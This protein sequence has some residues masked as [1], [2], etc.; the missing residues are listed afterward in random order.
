MHT[1]NE[2]E[3]LFALASGMRRERGEEEGLR[4]WAEE[5]EGDVVCTYVRR[6][7]LGCM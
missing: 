6:R 7:G 3:T 2:N 4:S 5:D 1:E